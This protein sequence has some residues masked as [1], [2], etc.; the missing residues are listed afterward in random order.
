MGFFDSTSSATDNRQAATDQGMI[1]GRN[2][3][4]YTAAGAVGQ[5]GG[6]TLLGAGATQTTIKGTK[7]N[8]TVQNMDPAVAQAAMD[9]ISGLAGQFGQNL[10]D[11]MTQSNN[12]ALQLAALNSQALQT[13]TDSVI[14]G[15]SQQEAGQQST[16]QSI[17]D[18]MTGLISNQQPAGTVQTNNTV[19]YM[20]LAV[21]ALVGAFF[22][23][24]SK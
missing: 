16:F 4:Q 10:S 8:V 12:N 5:T 9:Q 2:V 13:T 3:G 18:K 6:S 14:A 23:F 11:F 15:Q 24:R 1:F 21:L 19:L 7:G 20:A 17:L 22:Y